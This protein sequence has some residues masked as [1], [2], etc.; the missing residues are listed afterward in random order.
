MKRIVCVLLSFLFLMS[1]AACSL[2]IKKIEGVWR[3]A[4]VNG[5]G[6]AQYAAVTGRTSEEV[7]HTYTVSGKMI[8][9][10]DISGT[11]ELKPTMTESGF[12]VIADGEEKVFEYN[13]EY[14]VLIYFNKD[15]KWI[16]RR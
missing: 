8:I 5:S 4:E 14:D 7:E 13:E 15:E 9:Y 10:E 2:N 1:T 11:T 6:T 16:Y 12:V 3:L